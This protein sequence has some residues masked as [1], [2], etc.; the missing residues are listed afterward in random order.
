MVP[1]CFQ[2]FLQ[3]EEPVYDCLAEMDRMLINW[4]HIL[5][6]KNLNGEFCDTYPKTVVMFVFYVLVH[7]QQVEL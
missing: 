7:S 5:A 3:D 1:F 2:V 4:K 6:V